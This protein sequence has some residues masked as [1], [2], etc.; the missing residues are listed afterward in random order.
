MICRL[1]LKHPIGS[2]LKASKG[3]R[4]GVFSVRNEG[5]RRMQKGE[6]GSHGSGRYNLPNVHALRATNF[7]G[8]PHLEGRRKSRHE[9]VSGACRIESSRCMGR[10][11]GR[12]RAE[13]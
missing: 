7:A 11:I 10:L 6:T 3:S 8:E 4:E 2:R 12:Q 5:Q 1:G 9:A 13:D